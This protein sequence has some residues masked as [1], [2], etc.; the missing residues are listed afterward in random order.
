MAN[1]NPIEN[2][3]V[4]MLENRSFDNILGALYPHSSTFEGLLLDGSMSNTYNNNPVPVTNKF[5]GDD[6]FI[7]PSVDP[8]E[9]FQDMNLQIFDNTD[10]SGDANMGGFVNDWMAAAEEYSGLPTGKECPW[11]PSWPALPRFQ[12]GPIASDI[13]HYFTTA[14][15]SPQSS[16]TGQ[17]AQWFAVSDAWFGSSPTQTFPNRFFVNCATAGGYV[18]DVDYLCN[19]EVWPKLPSIFEL[20]DAPDGPSPNNWKVYFHD[21]AIATMINYVLEAPV[22][23]VRNFDD[24]DYG[25]DTKSPTFLQ[26]VSNQTLPRYSFI[27][28][29]YGGFNSLSPNSNHP[30]QNMLDG[31]ILLATV[32]NAI[33]QSS[34][35]WPRTLLIVTYDEHGGCFDHVV[36][37][38]AVSPGGTVL[39][40]PS[41]FGFDRYGPRVPA[42]LISPYIAAGTV[43]RPEGFAYNPV[44]S[45][46][47]TTN[48]VTPFDHTS[49]IKTI[50]ECFNLQTGGN[51][52]NLTAR[53][54]NAPSL[55]PVLT[56]GSQNMNSPG[57]V[58]V[59][60]SPNTSAGAA[61]SSSHVAEVVQEMLKRFG[62]K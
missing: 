52:A 47:T 16:V 12:S 22:E 36:P 17:L 4:L 1:T 62:N 14:G 23:Q 51:P 38:A 41:S 7:T 6:V 24:T 32:Y 30:P 54:H 26:D 42:I 15:A 18:Q 21:Y 31:E 49:I 46:I 11:A 13:M 59:P 5:S 53:D 58:A 43:L 28:P 35:Y 3:V 37:P 10:G 27:E 25:Q 61:A 40:R 34:F 60:T 2:I 8:G 45:G 29:R 48:G 20:L 56:L 55:L 9:S 44:S 33:A 50:V 57:P 39:P 19:L